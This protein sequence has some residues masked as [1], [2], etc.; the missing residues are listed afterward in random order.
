MGTSKTEAKKQ[1]R[2]ELRAARAA[3]QPEERTAADA[4]IAAQVLALPEY[5]QADL[6]LPYLSFGTEVDTR[7]IIHDAWERGKTVALPRCVEG[8]RDMRWFR[9]ESFEGLVKSPLGVE[10]PACDPAFEIGR[11]DMEGAIVLVPGLEFD[12]VGYR[13]GYGG[14]FYDVFLSAFDGVSI[15]LCRDCFLRDEPIECDA[16]DL[17]VTMVISESQV[18]RLG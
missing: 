13:L 6:L 17:P 4:G 10:E 1:R 12:H 15:G 18:I 11:E 16:H 14:G 5:E 7:A 3:L 2:S 9:V 8:S